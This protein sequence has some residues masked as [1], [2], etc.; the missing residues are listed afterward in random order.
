MNME[1][2]SPIVA[3]LGFFISGLVAYWKLYSDVKVHDAQIRMIFEKVEAVQNHANDIERNIFADIRKI[4]EE[5]SK[6]R[7]DLARLEGKFTNRE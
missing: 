5:L 7:E 3:G 4:L 1:I 6:M 2:S